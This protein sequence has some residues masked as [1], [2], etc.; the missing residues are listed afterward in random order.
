MKT[1][2]ILAIVALLITLYIFIYFIHYGVTEPPMLGDSHDYH[3]PIAKSIIDGSFLH[4]PTKLNPSIYYPG[5]S[6]AILSL[7]FLF[8]IP[9]N[10]FCLLGWAILFFLLIKLGKQFHLHG[11]LAVIFA[12]TFCGTQSILRQ[13]PTQSI[14]VW[15]AVFFVWSILLLERPKASLLY[16]LQIGFSLGM[17][18][19]SKF[20][21]PFFFLV[22]LFIYRDVFFK[23]FHIKKLLV[24]LIPFTILGLFWYIRNYLQFGNPLYPA[25]FLGL[26]GYPKFPLQDLLFY[27]VPFQKNGIVKLFEALTSEYLIWAF[28]LVMMTAYSIWEYR[29]K[30]LHHSTDINRLLFMSFL[31]FLTSFFLPMPMENIISNMRYLFPLFIPCIL[32]VFLIAQKYNLY[33][34]I[35]IIALLNLFPM[36]Y[37]LHYHPKLL[38]IYFIITGLFLYKPKIFIDK[39][40]TK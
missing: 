15:I 25:P 24:F 35:A 3:I 32:T 20:S 33:E 28:S 2:K 7:F 21:G 10:W 1:I 4:L 11:Y 34:Q 19:G 27:K 5:S 6:N 18:V 40:V 9:I 30:T 37:F 39:I 16:F 38:L 12:A 31:L 36:K 13:I 29:K 26:P 8:H 14:D 17:I 22:L 23:N